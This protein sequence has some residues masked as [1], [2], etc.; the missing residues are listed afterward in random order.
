MEKSERSRGRDINQGERD[1]KDMK[2]YRYY[3][4]IGYECIKWKEKDKEQEALLI[5]ED[6]EPTLLWSQVKKTRFASITLGRWMLDH[7]V[8]EAKV[9]V[10]KCLF[11]LCICKFRYK[12]KLVWA[13]SKKE[14]VIC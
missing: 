7:N 13:G 2:C 4:H 12:P 5:S 3:R 6:E 1:K 11:I 14:T 8:I 10:V 9:R